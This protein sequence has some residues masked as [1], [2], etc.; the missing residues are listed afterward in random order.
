MKREIIT[1]G[2]NFKILWPWIT[3]NAYMYMQ[4]QPHWTCLV[5]DEPTC[6]GAEY[7]DWTICKKSAS[8]QTRSHKKSH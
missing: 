8:R 3:V 1:Y 2:R 4:V 5:K 6:Q 7:N